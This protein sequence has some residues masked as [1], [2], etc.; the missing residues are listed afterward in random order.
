[1]GGENKNVVSEDLIKLLFDQQKEAT[2]SLTT[3]I[4]LSTTKMNELV[5]ALNAYPKQTHELLIK[6]D[7]SSKKIFWVVGGGLTIIAF[8]MGVVTY[9]G[10]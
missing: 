10:Y 4:V 9:T 5:L 3:A 6:H 8:L 7:E 2:S 1:M